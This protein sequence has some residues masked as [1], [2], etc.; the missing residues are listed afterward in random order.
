MELK[1]SSFYSTINIIQEQGIYKV[2]LY[3]HSTYSWILLADKSGQFPYFFSRPGSTALASEVD[4][5]KQTWQTETISFLEHH[6]RL[7]YLNTQLL[8]SLLTLCETIGTC[9]PGC[10]FQSCFQWLHCCVVTR[11]QSLLFDP[12]F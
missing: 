8:L 4:K 10:R 2:S 5:S 9:G 6:Y 7:K 3:S 1:G 11:C 12:L